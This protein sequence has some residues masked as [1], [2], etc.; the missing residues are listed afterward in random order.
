VLAQPRPSSSEV[1]FVA[2]LVTARVPH[3]VIAAGMQTARVG[4]YTRAQG[5]PCLR[6][7]SLAD[8]DADQ[9]WRHIG[10]QLSV[11]ELP[12]LGPSAL[13]ATLAAAEAARQMAALDTGDV[14]VAENA[15][16]QSGYRGGAWR[17]RLVVRHQQCSC[18]W[19]QSADES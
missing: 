13:M 3:L 16:M 12:T 4:P 11:D 5:G 10:A 7:D 1:E 9:V 8:S 2:K 6:C 18:W 19:P 17:R 14:V 15:V